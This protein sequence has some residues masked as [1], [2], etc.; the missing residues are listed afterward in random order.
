M[1]KPAP[2]KRP[3]NAV[4]LYKNE[5]FDEYKKSHPEK[6]LTEITS[7]LCAQY[8]TIPEA[9]KKK[10]EADFKAARDKYEK[11]APFNAGQ[12]EL[13]GGPRKDRHQEKGEEKRFEECGKAQKEGVQG[14][15][16]R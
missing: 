13:R 11:V 5:K 12:E 6:K 16:C 2:P 1:S 10:Y 4:F 8:K 7:D 3:M 9:D 15:V 14:Q